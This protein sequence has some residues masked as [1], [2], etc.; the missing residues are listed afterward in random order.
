MRYRHLTWLLALATAAT[1]CADTRIML[2]D[3]KRF[4]DGEKKFIVETTMPGDFKSLDSIVLALLTLS[5]QAANKSVTAPFFDKTQPLY[6]SFRG[7]RRKGKTVTLRFTGDAM[8]YLDSAIS[9]QDAIKGALEETIKLHA[10]DCKTVEY[11]VDGEVVTEW[12]A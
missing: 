11:E 8:S 12:D 7:L 10:P 4:A 6:Q 9:L 1:V 5:P 3:F 2:P